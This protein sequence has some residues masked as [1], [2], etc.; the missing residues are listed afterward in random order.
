MCW[1]EKLRLK[2]CLFI[3]FF[4]LPLFENKNRLYIITPWFQER[5]LCLNLKMVKIKNGKVTFAQSQQVK[6]E[7]LIINFHGNTHWLKMFNVKFQM[8]VKP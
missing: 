1:K 5:Q 3:S 7:N 8:T 4:V 2:G 6:H